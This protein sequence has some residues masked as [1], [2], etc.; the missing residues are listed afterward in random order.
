MTADD[1]LKGQPRPSAE[2][3]AWVFHHLNDLYESGGS[4]RQL[5]YARMGLDTKAYRMPTGQGQALSNR[6]HCAKESNEVSKLLLE[7]DLGRRA[8]LKGSSCGAMMATL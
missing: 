7:C 8:C 6:I 5:I 3:V 4:F 2:Q 1:H